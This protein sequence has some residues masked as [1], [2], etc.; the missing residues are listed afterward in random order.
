MEVH[1]RSC[2]IEIQA[3]R[4]Q[5]FDLYSVLAAELFQNRSAPSRS[6][7]M[8]ASVMPPDV[9]DDVPNP[10]HSVPGWATPLPDGQVWGSVTGV[11]LDRGHIWVVQRCGANS[12]IGSKDNPIL[13]F[14]M[15]G[16]LIKGFG[17]G[18]S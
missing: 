15:T 10:Y 14:D 5:D 1:G 9:S 13:E 8:S 16:K 3:C 4:S 18:C 7:A 12:C 11:A 17:A 6:S 2:S